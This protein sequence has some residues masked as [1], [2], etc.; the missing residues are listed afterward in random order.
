MW[1]EPAI[2]FLAFLSITI[3]DCWT[4]GRAKVRCGFIEGSFL[5]NSAVKSVNQMRRPDSE[6][7]RNSQECPYG[8]RPSR[9][10]LLPMTGRETKTN[11][12]LLRITMPLTK[13]LNS[14]S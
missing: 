1:A 5:V 2:C 13:F 10:N 7:L 14:N 11:H 8:D 12:V 3:K 6:G 9:L 4:Y